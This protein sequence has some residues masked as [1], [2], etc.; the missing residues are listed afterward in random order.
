[1]IM[2]PWA[3]SSQLEA[4]SMPSK[5]P[6]SLPA[7]DA[8]LE[9]LDAEVMEDPFLSEDI[10]IDSSID[11][12]LDIHRPED[13]RTKID[14]LMDRINMITSEQAEFQKHL[15]AEEEF[16]SQV[17]A[18][19]ETTRAPDRGLTVVTSIA[20]ETDFESD[21]PGE[22]EEVISIARASN[23]VKAISPKEIQ[24]IT[25]VP[26]AGRSKRRVKGKS[27]KTSLKDCSGTCNGKASTGPLAP[28]AEACQNREKSKPSVEHPISDFREVI[29]TALVSSD[30][31]IAP[32]TAHGLKSLTQRTSSRLSP[33]PIAPI[34]LSSH[35]K[36]ISSSSS[37]RQ[38]FLESRKN[39]Y[40][41]SIQNA[42]ST[43]ST[44]SDRSGKMRMR[45][46]SGGADELRP[47]SSMSR[48]V[49]RPIH[50]SSSM[51]SQNS[52]GLKSFVSWPG[53][54][55]KRNDTDD[56][57][58]LRSERLLHR[59]KTRDEKERSFEELIQSG[60][61]IVCTLTPDEIRG[62]EVC[63]G[64]QHWRYMQ[65]TVDLDT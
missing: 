40:S 49:P 3:I 5:R 17:L 52:Y 60:G 16:H 39:S 56:T 35:S 24:C 28:V 2:F 61:T 19:P 59:I 44:T 29:D 53:D 51:T 45:T 47:S 36:N 34:S 37:T 55:S 65:L 13:A 14:K 22:M 26:S 50:T 41:S 30:D 4:D 62:I 25:L 9:I 58:S 64:A 43:T 33:V 10:L 11:L 48:I 15:A 23:Y 32:N 1:M 6:H 21:G 46:S 57:S 20:D 63:T 8:P 7:L 54:G 12:S 38:E 42:P 18:S 27:S 31:E